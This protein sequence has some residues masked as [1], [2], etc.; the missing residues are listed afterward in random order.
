MNL[1]NLIVGAVLATTVGAGTAACGVGAYQPAYVVSRTMCGNQ[2]CVVMSDGDVVTVSQGIWSGVLYGMI[3]QSY[4][5]GYRFARGSYGTRSISTVSYSQYRSVRVVSASSE[6]SNQRT[7]N[8]YNSGGSSYTTSPRYKASAAAVKSAKSSSGVY[9]STSK[10]GTSKSSYSSNKTS[11]SGYK[12]SG[13][14]SSS[15]H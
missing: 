7:G 13:Y 10:Y 5:G 6:V 3:I 2:Y 11:Y 15:K 8:T 4:S 12:S 14:R 9:K 1:K